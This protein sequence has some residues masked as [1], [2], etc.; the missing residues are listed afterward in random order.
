MND[1]LKILL[2]QYLTHGITYDV[3]HYAQR[4]KKN[5]ALASEQHKNLLELGVGLG[6][7]FIPMHESGAECYG[8]DSDRSMLAATRSAAGKEIK[9]NLR[10]GKIESFLQPHQFSQI[11]VP[12]R[13]LQ[14][15]PVK[16]QACL[17]QCAAEHLSPNGEI[18]LHL[19]SPPANGMD[20]SWRIYRESAI[21]DGG[22][23]VIEEAVF[24]NDL[25]NRFF[26]GQ[27][28]IELRHRFQQF[29]AS[30]FSTGVWRL[31]HSLVSW[32]PEMFAKF[33]RSN[34]LEEHEQV[35]LSEGDW[36]SCCSLP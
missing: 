15:L 33:A 2:Y 21:V 4:A 13:T 23:M 22:T 17:L 14:L 8:I 28:T 30:G 34:G 26:D 35:Q 24:K 3:E 1:D 7:T 10:L 9:L 36:I 16:D 29:D 27:C 5:V 25:S 20:G 32:T 6:R 11:Q 18:L 31:A 12:L 19:C